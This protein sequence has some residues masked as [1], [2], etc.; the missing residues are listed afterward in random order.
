MLCYLEGQTQEEA[1]RAL[2][3][4]KGTVSGRLARAKD[5]LRSRLTRRGLASGAA[6]LAAYLVPDTAP[7][8]VPSSLLLPTVRAAIAASLAGIEAGLGVGSGQAAA[9]A[10]GILKTMYLGKIKAAV[11]LL[12][13][14]LGAAA[15]AA[16]KLWNSRSAGPLPAR[17][18]SPTGAAQPWL[19][20]LV[21]G[22][23]YTPDGKTAVSAQSDGLV[24]LWD[25]A[26]GQPVGT[27]NLVEN[28]AVGERA[29][30]WC[31]PSP[32]LPTAVS[33][34]VPAASTTTRR[35]VWSR[36]S[37][38]GAWPRPAAAH[39]RRCDARA[40]KPGHLAGGGKCRH[41]R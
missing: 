38:S 28:T 36:G 23:G 8:A 25:P 26:S 21:V 4:T 29:K 3:W 24:R 12:L 16:P 7:A 14:T 41:G 17:V 20:P 15:V 2:G 39:D 34:P 6:V 9:L 37:G 35:G 10:R 30:A 11:P 33:W 40:A 31:V 18:A 5:L 22:V 19:L 13:L 1:A 32:S 27:I